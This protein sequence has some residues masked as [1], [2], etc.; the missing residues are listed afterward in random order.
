MVSFNYNII[1]TQENPTKHPNLKQG[2]PQCVIKKPFLYETP[3]RLLGGDPRSINPDSR[4]RQTRSNVFPLN[5]ILYSSVN[6]FQSLPRVSCTS[7]A[8]CGCNGATKKGQRKNKLREGVVCLYTSFVNMGAR[9]GI[10]FPLAV[11]EVGRLE[12]GG[13]SRYICK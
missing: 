5:A 10:N 13:N 3:T 4:R 8:H 12:E 6:T 7:F 2:R 11:W 9:K 1:F